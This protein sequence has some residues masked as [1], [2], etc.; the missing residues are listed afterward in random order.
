MQDTSLNALILAAGFGTRLGEIGQKTAKGLFK[1]QQDIS[2]T[3]LIL[4]E[5][6]KLASI[7]NIALVSNQRFYQSY[8]QHLSQNYTRE[9]KTLN[10]QVTKPDDRLGSLG[11]LIFALDQLN[12]WN[13]NLLVLP[14]D[15]TPNSFLPKLIKLFIEKKCQ[16][17]VNCLIKRDKNKIRNK[18]GCALVNKQGRIID[19]EE[20]PNK[21][22]SNLASLPFYIFSPSALKL[23]KDYQKSGKNLDSPGHF[24]PWLV[25]HDH[26]IYSYVGSTHSFDIGDLDDLKR[27]QTQHSL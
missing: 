12:W 27:F 4:R 7:E 19:F 17:S 14:S 3:D 10:D 1:N 11:D 8:Q 21:P 22:K 20:K 13:Q 6:L 26:P 23:L 9:I 16:A 2:I 18:S 15:R 25:K 5:I 24:L